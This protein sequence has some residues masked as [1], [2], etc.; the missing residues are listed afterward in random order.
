MK[1]ILKKILS[2]KKNNV[3]TGKIKNSTVTITQINNEKKK[4]SE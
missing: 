2:S 1:E 4:K 3:C